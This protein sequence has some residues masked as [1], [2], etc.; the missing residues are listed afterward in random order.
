MG[1]NWK[2]I[3]D[4]LVNTSLVLTD[5]M[6]TNDPKDVEWT[7]VDDEGNE[8]TVSVPNIAK[9]LK[10]VENDLSNKVETVIGDYLMFSDKEPTNNINPKYKGF[11]YVKY[12]TDKPDRS[13][14]Y[15]C[16][17]NTENKNV[18]GRLIGGELTMYVSDDIEITPGVQYFVDTST[19]DITL[20][21]PT[22][23]EDKSKIII[24]DSKY[25]AENHPV[26]VLVG[27]SKINGE[28]NDL[29]CD[30]NGFYVGLI[31]DSNNGSWYIYNVTKLAS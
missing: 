30:V 5:F 9:V 12:N 2:A 25:N 31:Y 21:L 19:K 15:V 22:N 20:T 4:N 28:Q 27:D 18:W 3:S 6:D 29:V 14:L 13:E 23:P 16:V 1:L 11:L 26:T 10:N 7:Y 17:D 24:A 8:K